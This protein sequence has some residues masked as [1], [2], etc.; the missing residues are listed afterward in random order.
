MNRV[1]YGVYTFVSHNVNRVSRYSQRVADDLKEVY[2]FR[3]NWK[4]PRRN[5]R[6]VL[7]DDQESV[8][9]D[10]AEEK[11]RLWC[12]EQNKVVY[13]C[14]TYEANNAHRAEKGNFKFRVH[15]R[16]TR[17][18]T[19]KAVV[20]EKAAPQIAPVKCIDPNRRLVPF[21][22]NNVTA[23]NAEAL[24]SIWCDEMNKVVYGTYTFLR[25]HISLN[26]FEVLFTPAVRKP[27]PKMM[28]MS[29]DK[30]YQSVDPTD[31]WVQYTSENVTESN[32]ATLATIWCKE[33]NKVV[34]GTY[35]YLHHDAASRQF[36]VRFVP[37]LRKGSKKPT[38]GNTRWV[39]CDPEV[40]SE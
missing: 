31:R 10:N 9:K 6:W 33:M 12:E 21:T 32:A 5:T 29:V 1:S 39:E 20:A 3:V 38:S 11:G 14:Y 34:H 25:H 22:H 24:A 36:K 19:K 30:D 16:A 37:S 4:P 40:S 7:F 28:M 13:G 23:A 18:R 2:S 17:D 15:F 8:T 35:T 27:A 26:H